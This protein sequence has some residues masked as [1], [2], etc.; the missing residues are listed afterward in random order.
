MTSF[1]ER[2]KSFE[3]KFVMDAEL[4]FKVS[5]KRNR[6]LA[7]WVAIKMG[8]NDE[9]KENY[10]KEVI[11]ADFI[12]PGD[13]DVFKKIK[14]D[15]ESASIPMQDSEIRNQMKITLDRAKKDFI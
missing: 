2:Q 6:Y 9:E 10:I 7:E 1:D 14:F 12:E 15:F 3:K 8:K 4:Q 11:K 5:A 13:E